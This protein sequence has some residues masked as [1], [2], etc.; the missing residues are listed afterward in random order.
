MHLPWKG[1]A[2]ANAGA[3]LLRRTAAAG[4]LPPLVVVAFACSSS[5]KAPSSFTR[6]Q[7]MD[8]QT[9]K[10]CHP[11]QFQDWSASMHAYASDDPLFL[12]MNRRGQQQAQLGP[13]CVKCHAPLAVMTGKTVDG[14][15]LATLPQSL[16]GITCYYCHT[17]DSVMST[18]ADAG[19]A[20]ESG[21]G[22]VADSLYDN[23]LHFADDGLMRAAIRDP[24]SNDAHASSYSALHDGSRLES[25]QFC[26]SCHDVVNSHG[27]RIERTFEEWSHTLYNSAAGG[28]TCAQC[29]MRQSSGPAA[30]A[31]GL[32]TRNVH[33]HKFPGV[34]LPLGDVPTADPSVVGLEKAAV[35]AFL[36]TE[37]AMSLCVR[38]IPSGAA[39]IFIIVD[40]VASGHSWPSGAAQDRRAW[41]QVTASASG[42]TV[43]QSGVIPAGTEPTDP[44]VRAND[45]DLWLLRD[46]MLDSQGSLVHTFW[47]AYSSDSNSLPGPTTSDPL[48]PDFYRTHVMQTYP[49]ASGA[50]LP[51]YPDSVTLN[52]YLQAFPLDVF[53][54][55][56]SSPADLGMTASQV[57]AMRAN[58][59]PLSVGS[60]LTWTQA[61]ASDTTSGGS[62]YFDQGVPVMCVSTSS[63]NPQADKVPAPQ[64]KSAACTP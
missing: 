36:N 50:T 56:F 27:N 61:A 11:Q 19:P 10:Q 8:P 15:N 12:A 64:H 16:K 42:S 63:L 38:G 1:S 58:L 14:T 44:T 33:D 30:N 3:C 31:A 59:V 23:A 43:Y 2:L 28:N 18:H 26:G 24:A 54:D 60:T 48:N 53:D 5:P 39:S 34:D 22:G 9:C 7:L 46:C 21:E 40:N 49:R 13:F 35:Q 4:A 41:F 29:H 32:P 62:T 20:A 57:Q 17:A 51:S 25:A 55:L 47:D 6:E 37:L 45:P 52:V